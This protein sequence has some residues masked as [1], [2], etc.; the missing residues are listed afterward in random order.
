MKVMPEM[1]QDESGKNIKKNLKCACCGIKKE[2][3]LLR[4]SAE[5]KENS[6]YLKVSRLYSC[7]SCGEKKEISTGNYFFYTDIYIFSNTCCRLI[8]SGK[9]VED[10]KKWD[11]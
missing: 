2:H 6:D 11:D 9:C 3:K 5:K 8:E 7:G 10:M 4:R 1:I